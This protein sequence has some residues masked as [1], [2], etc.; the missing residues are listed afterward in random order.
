MTL[1]SYISH[2]DIITFNQFST[3]FYSNVS[4]SLSGLLVFLNRSSLNCN[5]LFTGETNRI[6]MMN[7]CSIYRFSI[8]LRLMIY[9][10]LWEDWTKIMAVY[11][12][13]VSYTAVAKNV[14]CFCLVA[15]PG[16]PRSPG[17]PEAAEGTVQDD[18]LLR[19]VK[20][21]LVRPSTPADL[22]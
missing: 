3:F 18:R 22:W 10:H 21:I 7:E 2:S 11:F 12:P 17:V 6:T 9:L 1:C 4:H 16:P 15:M 19:V 13:C 8:P 14:G 20:A 5:F